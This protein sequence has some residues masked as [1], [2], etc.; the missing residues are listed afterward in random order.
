M[1]ERS[2]INRIHRFEFLSINEAMC[3]FEL[4]SKFTYKGSPNYALP[5]VTS[6]FKRINNVWKILWMQRS[7]EIKICHCGISIVKRPF[8]CSNNLGRS[9]F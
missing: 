6:I 4:G 8:I 2:E 5:T 7:S 9:F 3:I 1:K